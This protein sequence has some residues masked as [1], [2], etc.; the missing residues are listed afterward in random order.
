MHAVKP[1]D[2]Y[3]HENTGESNFNESMYFNFYD[4]AARLGGFARVGNRANE[5]YAEVTLAVYQP[6]GTALFNY[7]RPEIADNS[8]FNAG[9]MK[10]EVVE[11]VKHLRVSYDGTAVY[12]ARPLELENPKRAFTSNPHQPVTLQ[13][14][15]A[16]LSPLYGGESDA[17]NSAMVFAKGHYE[18]HVKAVGS[19]TING[20]TTPLTGHG[21]RDHS[22]GPRSWQSP[23]Y[24]R[25]LTCEFDD[26]FGFMGSQIVMRNGTELLSGFVFKDGENHF[27]THLDLHTDWAGEAHYHDRITAKLHTAIGDFDIRGKVLTM[28]PLRNRKDGQITRISEG[29]TEWRCGNH[30]GYGL[31]EYL[32]QVA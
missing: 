26:D 18:Q 1:Q 13:L 27:V 20:Q 8:A 5:R 32:D 10:F 11:P 14:D 4:R 25:W 9:G 24:Y 30:V 29:M 6:D 31:S 19:I 2:E 28:I 17:E 12:L 16:G 15:Y 7:M 21:L 23:T 3:M 22:W